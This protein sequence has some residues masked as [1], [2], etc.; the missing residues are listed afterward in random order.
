MGEGACG[1]GVGEVPPERDEGPAECFR[2]TDDQSGLGPAGGEPM[3]LGPVAPVPG[4][5][6]SAGKCAWSSID[7]ESWLRL[8]G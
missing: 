7:A 6:E 3:G 5:V 4:D 1:E 8:E 2:A